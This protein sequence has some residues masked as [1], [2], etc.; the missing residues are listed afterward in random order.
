M[1]DAYE[2][3]T[4]LEGKPVV[5]QVIIDMDGLICHSI[6]THN[7]TSDDAID[8]ML[9]AHGMPYPGVYDYGELDLTKYAPP[10]APEPE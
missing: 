6:F 9:K 7:I 2:M 5:V 3:K 4:I 8:L 10:D 1:F